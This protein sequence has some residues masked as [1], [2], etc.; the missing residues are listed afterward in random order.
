MADPIAL[1]QLKAAQEQVEAAWAAVEATWAGAAVA[2]LVLGSAF[3]TILWQ[4]T[5]DRR[6]S[7]RRRQ[8]NNLSVLVESMFTLNY[9]EF[10]RD[11]CNDALAHD[12]QVSKYPILF[13]LNGYARFLEIASAADEVGPGPTAVASRMIAISREVVAK[14]F[15]LCPDDTLSREQITELRAFVVLIQPDL[16]TV[17]QALGHHHQNIVATDE[18][19][20]AKREF[21]RRSRTW[22]GGEKVMNML[23]GGRYVPIT[24]SL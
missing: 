3:V 12:R 22:Q 17:W 7:E 10:C 8:Y 1:A 23:S 15:R 2:V 9:V 6:R 21:C 19:R 5:L 24:Q 11:F 4:R 16:T 14:V 20:W 18:G 13:Y